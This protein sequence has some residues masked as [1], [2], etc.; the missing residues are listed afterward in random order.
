MSYIR[1]TSNPEALYIWGDK[2][3]IAH[4]SMGSSPPWYMPTSVL[5]GLIRKFNRQYGNGFD[6]DID[7]V[8]SYRKA[9]LMLVKHGYDFKVCLAYN[10]MVHGKMVEWKC[11]MW[12]VT[13]MYIAK[14]NDDTCWK[15]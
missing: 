7:E 5:N 3:K 10:G 13:W 15:R 8:L 9:S 14:N 11:F 1:S 4:I 6:L 2:E 12:V